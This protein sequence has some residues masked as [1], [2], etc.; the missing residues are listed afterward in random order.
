MTFASLLIDTITVYLLSEVPPDNRYGDPTP[1][2]DGGTAYSARVQPASEDELQDGIQD[3]RVQ[4]L[5]VFTQADAVVNSTATID[6]LG[7]LYEVEG[8]VELFEDGVGPHHLEF[9]MRR[10]EGV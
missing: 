7:D 1:S 5:K 2:F 6:Y 8:D 4:L 3:T 9:H 10:T